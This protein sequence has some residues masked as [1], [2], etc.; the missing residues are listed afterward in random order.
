M[1]NL[2]SQEVGVVALFALIGV[3][4]VVLIALAW[5][6]VQVIANWKIFKKMGEP[7]WKSI[8]PFYNLY[9]LYKRTWK[10]MFFWIALVIGIIAG[11]F[12]SLSQTMTDQATVFAAIELVFLI[13]ALVLKIIGDNKLSKSF[14]HGAGFTVGLVFLN[15][16]FK[17]IL[18]F[19]SSKYVGN[20]TD[21]TNKQA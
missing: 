8:I 6:V 19:G 11:V 18:G 5:Y 10:T 20:T 17:L 2:T 14:G 13:A 4:G 16:I 7:G 15:P 9:I 1:E 3:T 12:Q 21:V